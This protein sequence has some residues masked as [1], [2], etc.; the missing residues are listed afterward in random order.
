[1]K[2]VA[3]ARMLLVFIAIAVCSYHFGFMSARNT[4]PPA[5]DCPCKAWSGSCQCGP[6]CRSSG[7]RGEVGCSK[8]LLRTELRSGEIDRS[9]I[10]R[11]EVRACLSEGR[12]RC[13]FVSIEKRTGE[14]AF[15]PYLDD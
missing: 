7:N 5:F 12:D 2:K 3:V 10:L 11:P 1:M 14:P 13:V 6:D 8:C 15:M 9:L 4:P